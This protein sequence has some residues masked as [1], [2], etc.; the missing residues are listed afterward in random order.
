MEK[1]LGQHVYL[2]SDVWVYLPRV[3]TDLL[4]KITEVGYLRYSSWR[5][6]GYYSMHA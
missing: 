5:L 2:D 1:Q 4:R 3:E 6:L